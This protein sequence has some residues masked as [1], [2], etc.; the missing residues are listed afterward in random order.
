MRRLR[1]VDADK[2]VLS[3]VLIA[4]V[5]IKL[6]D[7]FCPAFN[8]DCTQEFLRIKEETFSGLLFIKEYGVA[9]SQKYSVLI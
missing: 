2:V 8:C 6:P 1:K 5:L 9:E 7:I 3:F 4:K